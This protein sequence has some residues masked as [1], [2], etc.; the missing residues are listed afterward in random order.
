MTNHKPIGRDRQYE[1]ID[2][3]RIVRRPIPEPFKYIFLLVILWGGGLFAMALWVFGG[4]AGLK[5][6]ESE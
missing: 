3:Y 4:Y 5:G 2:S 1:R 6:K